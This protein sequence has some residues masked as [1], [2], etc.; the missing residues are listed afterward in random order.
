MWKMIS[1]LSRHDD[2]KVKDGKVEEDFLP[3]FPIYIHIPLPHM[4][5]WTTFGECQ[6]LK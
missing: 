4:P 6:I 2:R 5:I 1:S 3:V